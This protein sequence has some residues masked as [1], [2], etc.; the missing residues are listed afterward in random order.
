MRI[1]DQDWRA[2]ARPSGTERHTLRLVALLGAALLLATSACVATP[3]SSDAELTA[4]PAGTPS[5]SSQPPSPPPASAVVEPAGSTVDGP[6]G[7][8]EVIPSDG[9]PAPFT[10]GGTVNGL[11]GTL[12]LENHRGL[13][14]EVTEDG[15]F[16]F[17][18]IPTPAGE[19]YFVK[20]FN[21]PF[22][23][24]QTCTVTN[25]EGTFTDHDVTDVVVDCV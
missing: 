2:S 7:P 17:T 16:T 1:D 5:T 21:Q 25:G 3:S 6:D 11:V 23:P 10:V 4:S 19:P 22:Q 24:T 13:F 18:D 20:V 9:P 14:L 8:R 12:V 15:P